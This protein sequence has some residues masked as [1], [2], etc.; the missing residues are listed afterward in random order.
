[1]RGNTSV[2]QEDL[3]QF[4]GLTAIEAVAKA[5]SE[6]GEFP[7]WHYRMQQIVRKTMPVLGR[8]LDRLATEY[9][10]HLERVTRTNQ[11]FA[12]IEAN[13]ELKSLKGDK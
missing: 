11:M 3:E 7:T 5:W 2:T 12:T 6:S 13:T 4:D 8:A 10:A 9:V 1:M